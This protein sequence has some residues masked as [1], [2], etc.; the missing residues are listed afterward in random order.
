MNNELNPEYYLVEDWKDYD[1]GLLSTL[2]NR[3]FKVK[4]IN[5]YSLNTGNPIP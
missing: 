1:Q 5:A 3:Y 2:G 4:G